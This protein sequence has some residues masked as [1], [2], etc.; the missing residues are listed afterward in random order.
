MRV[1]ASGEPERRAAPGVLPL[2]GWVEALGACPRPENGRVTRLEL[3]RSSRGRE[4]A[5]VMENKTLIFLTSCVTS[6][7]Q[8]IYTH[9]I[10]FI[11]QA[12]SP[13]MHLMRTIK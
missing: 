11:N 6:K 1:V 2:R 4:G 3:R 5:K 10:L 8:L 7:V 9:G 12:C 13:A